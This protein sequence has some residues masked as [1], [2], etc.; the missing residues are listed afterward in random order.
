MTT[1][2]R[3]FGM[4][5]FGKERFLNHYELWK[6]TVHNLKLFIFPK[7]CSNTVLK[8]LHEELDTSSIPNITFSQLL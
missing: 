3:D 1:F 5:I 2:I 7:N 6:Q 4:F 8:Q